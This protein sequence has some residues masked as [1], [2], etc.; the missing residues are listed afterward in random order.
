MTDVLLSTYIL[1]CQEVNSFGN[2]E[3]GLKFSFTHTQSSLG[4]NASE[5]PREKSIEKDTK[6]SQTTILDLSLRK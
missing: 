3:Y 5:R 6:S 4:S 2:S 1:N